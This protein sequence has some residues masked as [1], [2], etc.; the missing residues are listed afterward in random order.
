MEILFPA[1]NNTNFQFNIEKFTRI[2]YTIA[3]VLSTNNW[4]E[5]IDRR[6]FIK[7]AL[8]K[9]F[10]TFIIHIATLEILA[11]MLVYLLKTAQIAT[12]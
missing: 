3:E 4:M 12:L 2:I 6:K 1:L 10:E 7:A 5:F 9:I 8:N 11:K